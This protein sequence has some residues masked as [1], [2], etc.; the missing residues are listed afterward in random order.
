VQK[1]G[2]TPR[3]SG[4]ENGPFDDRSIEGIQLPA[5]RVG[6]PQSSLEQFPQVNPHK[7]TAQ[8]VQIR[9]E[10]QAIHQN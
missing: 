3:H 1:G 8:W 6:Q 4:N 7:K 9:L 2:T 5:P 10:F